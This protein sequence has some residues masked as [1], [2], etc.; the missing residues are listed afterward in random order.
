VRDILA[1]VAKT[2]RV[3]CWISQNKLEIVPISAYKPGEAVVINAKT[4]AICPA[5]ILLSLRH[6]QR[7]RAEDDKAGEY[8][9]RENSEHD[10][11]R[12]PVC[13]QPIE[14]VR[15]GSILLHCQEDRHENND[16]QGVEEGGRTSGICISFPTYTL[17]RGRVRC[18]TKQHLLGTLIA[19]HK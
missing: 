14:D 13:R 4:G 17:K 8:P 2:H 15:H 6:G 12:R 19:A 16:R 3:D 9:E 5:K 11:R 1:D 7:H 18:Y 10:Q